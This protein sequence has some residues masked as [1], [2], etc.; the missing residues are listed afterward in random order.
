[1]VSANEYYEIIRKAYSGSENSEIASQQSRYMKYH[2]E[3][4]G[5]KAPIWQGIIREIF[6]KEGILNGE[7]L[8]E[9]ITTC[10]QDDRREMQYA[11]IAMSQ[12]ALKK[13][14]QDFI[15]IIEFMITNKSWWDSV[16]WISAHIAGAFF[17]RFPELLVPIT[18]KWMASGNIWLQRASI[19]FQLKYKSKTNLVLLSKYI[20]QTGQSKE[21]FL[22]KAAGWALRTVSY[23]DPNFVI[24]F[25]E[26]NPGLSP[27]TKKEA[28]R[29]IL[30][31]KK[32]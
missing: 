18:E 20:V 22:R 27:L 25:V 32:D 24:S 5:L 9:F 13:Q 6:A 17:L 23:F 11:A 19:L 28:M 1:M 29:I 14:D 2:F 15:K 30:K 16:D 8:K 7:P 10:F 26:N 31:N 4:F 21:I 12:K 3:Y